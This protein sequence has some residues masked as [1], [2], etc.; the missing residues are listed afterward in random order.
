MS[1]ALHMVNLSGQLRV[2]QGFADLEIAR[3]VFNLKKSIRR[4]YL[5]GSIVVEETGEVVESFDHSTSIRKDQ[6]YRTQKARGIA[7]LRDYTL[8]DYAE[9]CGK[10]LHDK[11]LSIF[12]TGI[13]HVELP[14][15]ARPCPTVP[16][17]GFV[18]SR[19]VKSVYELQ[20]VIADTLTQDPNG[21]VIL[22]PKLSG[23]WSGI[24]THASVVYGPG[25]DGATSGKRA[26]T[27][28]C[29]TSVNMFKS[30]VGSYMI[31]HAGVKNA[32]YLEFVED[33][34]FPTIV[35]LRDGPPSPNSPNFI[36][37]RIEVSTVLV[38]DPNMDLLQWEELVNDHKD[39]P[40]LV[41]YHPGGALSSHFA[42][43]AIQHKIPVIIEG[44]APVPG[45]ILEPAGWEP[46]PPDYDQLASLIRY[47]LDKGFG[48]LSMTQQKE[49]VMAS[50]ATLHTS[51]QWGPD[52]H[53]Q[54]LR[55]EGVVGLIYAITAACV[56]EMRH[57]YICGPGRSRYNKKPELGDIIKYR[58]DDREILRDSVYCQ[59]FNLNSD[60]ISRMISAC[61]EDFNTYGWNGT[62]GGGSWADAAQKT[63]QMLRAVRTFVRTPN[64]ANWT[65]VMVHY[66]VVVNTCHNGDKVL[67]KWVNRHTLD[68]LALIP[69]LGLVNTFVAHLVL[70]VYEAWEAR[71]DVHQDFTVIQ[72][73]Q[74]EEPDPEARAA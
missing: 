37:S 13:T 32:P 10:Q 11:N 18:E 6:M 35:Q 49:L 27:I 46:A 22:M 26:L 16:R 28:P 7:A 47:R 54:R 61:A 38:V 48:K 14:A 43:H 17:H 36:P 33:D 25:N 52:F 8:F 60:H 62:Y 70:P 21:E 74:E 19:L 15:F 51:S 44:E 65:D 56:G 41:V 58:T 29:F 55:A 4:R 9:W 40:G 59:L 39:I 64:A 73:P 69:H 2:E 68:R 5:A 20:R 24:M 67:T 72:S 66:N 63:V 31:G 50:V 57:W 42:V 23:K 53:L 45:S 1:Y 12:P 34:G 30:M 3:Y 71:G